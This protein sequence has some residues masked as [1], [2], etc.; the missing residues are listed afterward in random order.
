[1]KDERLCTGERLAGRADRIV[2]T[3]VGEKARTRVDVASRGIHFPGFDF[4]WYSGDLRVL[5]LDVVRAEIG[6]RKGTA[7]DPAR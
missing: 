5:L 4:G 6:R 2:L 1:M 7:T 3:F